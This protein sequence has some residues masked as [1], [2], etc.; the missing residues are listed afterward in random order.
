MPF[1]PKSAISAGKKSKRGLLKKMQ[2]GSSRIENI[3][4][5]L[6]LSNKK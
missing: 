5:N 3:N 4:Y 2:F 6:N 1:D